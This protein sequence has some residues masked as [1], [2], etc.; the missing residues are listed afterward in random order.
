MERFVL[1][2]WVSAEVADLKVNGSG[3]CYMELIEKGE[4]DGVA[5]AQARGVIWRSSWGAISARFEAETGARLERGFKILAKVQVNYNELYGLSLQITDIDPTYTL[6]ESERQRQLAIKRLKENDSYDKNREL[7]L[8]QLVQRIAIVSSSK[9]AGYQDFM[10]EITKSE[11][12]FDLTLFE[13]TMQGAQAEQSII[14]ALIAIANRREEF[15]IVAVLR[16]GGST[17]D[18]NCFDSY[19]LALHFARFPRPVISGI[20]HDKDI[21]VVDLV[22]H[23]SVKTPTAVASWFVERMMQLDGWL[24]NAA[25]QLQGYSVELARGEERHL[26]G[27]IKEIATRTEELINRKKR[28]LIEQLISLPELAEKRIEDERKRLDNSTAIIDSYS[29]QKLLALG[30]AIA[31]HQDTRRNIDTVEA[32]QSGESI[33]LQLRDGEIDTEIK[34]IK[35]YGTEEVKL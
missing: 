2:V 10:R 1:P 31:R 11:Y 25:Q 35:K 21:S 6:G 14:D 23:V 9:A 34:T 26:E 19:R 13:A 28:E 16:G 33:T 15:D 20:G 22:A 7:E 24:L 4:S 18:L 5:R 8:P 29:P 30:F 17:N 3:H 32:L 27:H 12:H